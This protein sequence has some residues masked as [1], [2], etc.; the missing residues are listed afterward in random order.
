[1]VLAAQGLL[2]IVPMLVA[3]AAFL[4]EALDRVA[5]E[6][7]GDIV[8]GSPAQTKRLSQGLDYDRVGAARTRWHHD[9][10][11]LGEELCPSDAALL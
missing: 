2:V 7:F 4:P 8:G 6:R 11:L 5:L 3:M 1:M 9:H 10:G